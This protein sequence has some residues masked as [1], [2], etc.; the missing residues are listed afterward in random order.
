MAL[1]SKSTARRIVQMERDSAQGLSESALRFVQQEAGK[2]AKKA[3]KAS[4][5]AGQKARDLRAGAR[6]V[7]K[8]QA[9]KIGGA[10][11][12]AGK[13]LIRKFKK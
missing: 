4:K 10:I 2:K 1:L 5:H 8:A 6:F 9:T 12:K 11:R 7:Q 13:A 3:I